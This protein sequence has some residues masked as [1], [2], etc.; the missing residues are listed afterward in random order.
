MSPHH[1]GL[2]EATFAL[3]RGKITPL[4]RS[5]S[6]GSTREMGRL[7]RRVK[8]F[9]VRGRW[10]RP[11]CTGPAPRLELLGTGGSCPPKAFQLLAS[12][13][14]R[15]SR[16]TSLRRIADLNHIS[17]TLS[18]QCLVECWVEWGLYLSQEAVKKE[19]TKNNHL[20]KYPV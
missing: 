7:E 19:A 11:T 2:E 10:A 20:V 18:Q 5:I 13:L 8:S 3:L 1:P 15:C 12:G 9:T 14:S 6:Q 16:V 4:C 17:R